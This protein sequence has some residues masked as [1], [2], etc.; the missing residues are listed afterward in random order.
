LGDTSYDAFEATERVGISITD[1]FARMW[2]SEND[3]DLFENLGGQLSPVKIVE[4][5]QVALATTGLTPGS[6]VAT[7]DS[8][9]NLVAPTF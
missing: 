7:K 4:S 5:N 2:G 1:E 6:T 3:S 8:I 9:A